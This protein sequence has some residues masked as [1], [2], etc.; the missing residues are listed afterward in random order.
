MPSSLQKAAAGQ[1]NVAGQQNAAGSFES[2]FAGG[3]DFSELGGSSAKGG[4][5]HAAVLLQLKQ[6]QAAENR[7]EE[8]EEIRMQEI[9]QKRVQNLQKKKNVRE[10]DLVGALVGMHGGDR[11]VLESNHRR[12]TKRDRIKTSTDNKK[13]RVTKKAQKHKY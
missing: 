1:Q 9:V 7:L 5:S 13:G 6:R 3:L 11:S 4:S 8:Q 2:C 12:T 10:N